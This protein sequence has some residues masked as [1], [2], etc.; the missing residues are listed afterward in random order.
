MNEWKVSSHLRAAPRHAF[1][2]LQLYAFTLFWANEGWAL[3]LHGPEKPAQSLE[4][5]NARRRRR[6][7]NAHLPASNSQ[8]PARLPV[9]KMVARRR[10]RAQR[11]SED[12]IP[13]LLGYSGEGWRDTGPSTARLCPEAS[14]APAMARQ[15]ERPRVSR[16]PRGA[17]LGSS[18]LSRDSPFS[19]CRPWE[20]SP[21]SALSR[22]RALLHLPR[23]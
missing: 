16:D 7:G 21:L 3:G 19:Q 17:L 2:Y 15:F 11:S 12:G 22:R 9:G 4:G 5:G 10:K 1:N 8:R 14:R 18:L 6:L 20:N 13:G 23:R